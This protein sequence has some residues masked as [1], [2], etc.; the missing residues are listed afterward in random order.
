MSTVRSEVEG[1]KEQHLELTSRAADLEAGTGERRHSVADLEAQIQLL[2]SQIET[3][4]ADRKRHQEHNRQPGN[5]PARRG[6]V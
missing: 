3:L 1:E 5:G 4:E 2:E 6:V